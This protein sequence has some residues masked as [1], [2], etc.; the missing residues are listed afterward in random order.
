MCFV[1]RTILEG[2][3]EGESPCT[4]KEWLAAWG[5][6]E[7][8]AKL[9]PDLSDATKEGPQQHEEPGKRPGWLCRGKGGTPVMHEA[10]ISIQQK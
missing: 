5:G 9:L 6:G 1:L 4:A 2:R 7:S 3:W 10:P 8:L